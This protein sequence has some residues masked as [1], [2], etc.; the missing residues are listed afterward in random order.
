MAFFNRIFLYQV[1]KSLEV[2]SA[3]LKGRVKDVA[4]VNTGCSATTAV[5]TAT[6]TVNTDR[7][8]TT[9]V[10]TDRT[11]TTAVNTDRTATTAVNTDRTATT[12]APVTADPLSFLEKIE[13]DGPC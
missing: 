4:V 6:G 7:S 8:A 9:A 11:A 2:A 5:N 13:P 12:A 1:H 3:D 10:N